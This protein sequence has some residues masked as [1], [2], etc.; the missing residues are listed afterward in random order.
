MQFAQHARIANT[1][2]SGPGRDQQVHQPLFMTG[3][4]VPLI[5]V[6]SP[7]VHVET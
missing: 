1:V 4:D 6:C 5:S 7:F 2:Q 3:A